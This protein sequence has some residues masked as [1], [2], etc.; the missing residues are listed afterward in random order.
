MTFV[1]MVDVFLRALLSVLTFKQ[2]LE[3]YLSIRRSKLEILDE[4][5]LKPQH[6]INNNVHAS[7]TLITLTNS[8]NND[9]N[10]SMNND[11]NNSINNND[12]NSI[13]NNDNN[14][15]N[16]TTIT[17]STT[18]TTTTICMCAS[19]VSSA[20]EVMTSSEAEAH[21]KQKSIRSKIS[22]E[23]ISSPEAT[24]DQ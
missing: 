12:N 16:A 19:E 8:T 10:N 6:I 5:W 24:V 14:S 2:T 13:N 21:Q 11:D 17:Q 4:K 15:I 18:T 9:D 20:S 23:A 1:F 22:S 3:T 7:S